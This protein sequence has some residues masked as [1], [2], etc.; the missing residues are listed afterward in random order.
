MYKKVKIKQT[1]LRIGFTTL[2]VIIQLFC[3]LSISYWW[4]LVA[5]VSHVPF[6]LLLNTRVIRAD[7][8]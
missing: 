4:H 5:N 7:T 6:L 3:T 2:L 1:Y 8:L